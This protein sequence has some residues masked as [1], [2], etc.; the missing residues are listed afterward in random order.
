MQ[1]GY[2]A[3]RA[4]NVVHSTRLRTYV[5]WLTWMPAERAVRYAN[6]IHTTPSA[7]VRS[8]NDLDACIAGRIRLD[9]RRTFYVILRVCAYR[10]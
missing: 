4:F 1:S 6:V 7:Y 9:H 8:V 3:V 5:L 10:T 2:Q